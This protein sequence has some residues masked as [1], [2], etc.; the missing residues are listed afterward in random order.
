MKERIVIFTMGV[1]VLAVAGGIVY[2]ITAANWKV[3]A[4]ESMN[5]VREA[6]PESYDE[7]WNDKVS[8]H[9]TVNGHGLASGQEFFETSAT[10]ATY[11]QEK[12]KEV[13][14]LDS[15]LKPHISEDYNALGEVEEFTSY[16]WDEYLLY[17]T[18]TTITYAKNDLWRYVRSPGTD[19]ILSQAPSDGL[20]WGTRD[21]AWDFL[22][23]SLLAVEMADEPLYMSACY[24][25]D[26]EVLAD[27]EQQWLLNGSLPVEEL[28]SG[29]I[30]IDES[31]LKDAWTDSDELYAF[32]FQQKNQGMPLY[33]C[34]IVWGGPKDLD[35]WQGEAFVTKDGLNSLL[36]NMW[37]DFEESDSV[38][39]KL[40]PFG[41]VIDAA[42][43]YSQKRTDS[44]MTEFY[45]ADLFLLPQK[46][47]N[48]FRIVPVWIL[49]Y[50]EYLEDVDGYAYDNLVINAI[51]GELM[52]T[53]PT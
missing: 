1:F 40:L 43:D 2:G 11:N 37:V 13:F 19:P 53:N 39:G 17:L 21:E 46:E 24:A 18:P 31:E 27:A 47:D 6:F 49:G 52:D 25:L 26:K 36:L 45:R 33:G 28:Q 29:S 30:C 35:C 3:Q 23:E 42:K 12:A 51:S 34:P 10:L 9:M 7:D 20:A 48:Y 5:I 15:K 4:E 22:N 32:Y 44:G 38:E 41:S 8:F 16:V 14:Q 50:S